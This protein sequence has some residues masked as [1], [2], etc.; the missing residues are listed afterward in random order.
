MNKDNTF[1]ETTIKSDTIYEGRIIKLRVDTVELPNK[2]YSKREIVE[3]SRGVAMVPLTKD[4]Q[5]ILVKQYRK[6]VEDFTYEIPAG[7]V[8][9]NENI[10]ETAIRELQ[11]EIGFKP[12]KLELLTES[13]VS[14]GFTDEKISIFLASDLVESKLDQDDTE[15]IE[16]VKLP[17][18]KAYE[19]IENFEISDAKTI[20]GI[21]FA[22]RRID[23]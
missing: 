7:M 15:F 10:Q 5:I 23:E 20:I 4:N 6:A 13:Y 12:G 8:E 11:E 19:M 16:V 14:P 9:V 21:L 3:H 22:L 1:E 18:L 2:I 17:L